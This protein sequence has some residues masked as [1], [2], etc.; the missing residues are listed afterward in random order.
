MTAKRK[1]VF[2]D[3]DGVLIDDVGFLAEPA[4][5][6]WCPNVKE[7]LARL[8]ELGFLNV[9]TSNQSGVARGFFS[10]DDVASVHAHMLRTLGVTDL[11][12]G[13]VNGIHFCP[14]LPDGR[15]HQYSIECE[16]RKPK[17]GL[18]LKAAAEHDV[19]VARSYLIGDAIRDL[20]AGRAAGV[21]KTVL[22]LTGKGREVQYRT[23][24]PPQADFVAPDLLAAAQWIAG[25]EKAS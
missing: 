19:D 7:G 9:I 17:P 5:V 16:C 22:V 18:I 20:E 13:L 23:P 24:N 11:A 1:A 14:H 2:L 10:M 21:K 12:A 6:K 8:R 4:Q 15:V 25:Q 3:R